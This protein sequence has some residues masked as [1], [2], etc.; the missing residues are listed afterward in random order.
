MT[1]INIRKLLVQ[2]ISARLLLQKG[3]T[4]LTSAAGLLLFLSPVITFP[5]DF[6]NYIN[7]QRSESLIRNGEC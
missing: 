3:K 4:R 7:S 2:K 1:Q 5:K 6:F